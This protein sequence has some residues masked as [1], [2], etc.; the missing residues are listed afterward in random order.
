[1]TEMKAEVKWF[2]ILAHWNPDGQDEERR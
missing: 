1:M 2:I